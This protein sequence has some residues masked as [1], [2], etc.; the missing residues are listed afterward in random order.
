MGTVLKTSYDLACERIIAPKYTKKEAKKKGM[1]FIPVPEFN[2][3]E[4]KALNVIGYSDGGQY[5]QET[6]LIEHP[7]EIKKEEKPMET[8]VQEP[9]T[10]NYS[11]LVECHF[12]GSTKSWSGYSKMNRNLIFGLSNRNTKVKVEDFSDSYDVNAETQKQIKMMEDA[13][14]SPKAP[15]IYSMTVPSSV[16]HSGKKIAYTMIESSSLHKDYCEKLNMMDELWVPSMFGKKLMQKYRIHPPIHVMPL[17]VDTERYKPNCGIMNFGS[18]MRSFKFLCLSKYS[19]R[20]GFD[21]LLRAFMEEFSNDEDVSLLLV[22]SALN[23][24]AGQ[25]GTNLIVN[26][27]NDIKNFVK[28][29]ENELPHVA[30]Y[31]KPLFERDMPK[32]YNSC[33]AFCLISRGEGMSLTPLEAAACG[34]PVIASNVTAHTDFLKSDNSYLIEPDGYIEAKV[35]GKMSN[36]AKLCHFYDGQQFPDFSETGVEQTRSQMRNVFDNYKEAQEKAQKLRN[37]VLNNYTWNMGID[38]VYKRLRDLQ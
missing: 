3:R 28:K 24:G 18:A 10:I 6:K 38:K 4:D 7:E 8:R 20:K 25:K 5:A 2:D 1:D 29:P 30:L 31:T 16:T 23:T 26:D 19:Y 9:E 34:L 37:L 33:N 17:G 35:N 13:D 11:D 36:M 27:F 21:I 12:C 14:I 15:K 32:V 22:T